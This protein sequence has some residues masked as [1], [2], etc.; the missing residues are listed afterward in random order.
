MMRNSKFAQNKFSKIFIQTKL[1]NI[2]INRI[3]TLI[4]VDIQVF[5]L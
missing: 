4:Q 5:L 2:M 3:G 1:K